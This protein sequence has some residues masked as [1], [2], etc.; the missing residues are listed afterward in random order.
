[1]RNVFNTGTQFETQYVL[2][3]KGLEMTNIQLFYI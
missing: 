2:L 1:M 3:D